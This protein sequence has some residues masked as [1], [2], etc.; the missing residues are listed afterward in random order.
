MPQVGPLSRRQLIRHLRALGFDGPEPGGKHQVMTRGSV[1]L[2]IPNLHRT[3]DIGVGLLLR[4][5][6]QAGISREEW[7]RL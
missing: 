4:L 1:T 2:T 6:A 3:K 7:E 5:L